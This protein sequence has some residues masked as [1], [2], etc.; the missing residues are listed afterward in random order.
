MLDM[1]RVGRWSGLQFIKEAVIL[2]TLGFRCLLLP[3][4]AQIFPGGMFCKHYRGD[5]AISNSTASGCS[6]TTDF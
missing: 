4:P 3:K 2:C 6:K 5:T 1:N